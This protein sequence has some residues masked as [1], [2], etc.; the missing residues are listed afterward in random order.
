[1][2]SFEKSVKGATKIKVRTI[3]ALGSNGDDDGDVI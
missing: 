3:P 1:M 2:S